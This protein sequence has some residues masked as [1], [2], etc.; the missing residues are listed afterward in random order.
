MLFSPSLSNDCKCSQILSSAII[1]LY[2]FVSFSATR[3][4]SFNLGRMSKPSTKLRCIKDI[5]D[6]TSTSDGLNLIY[7]KKKIEDKGKKQSIVLLDYQLNW[8]LKLSMDS[9]LLFHLHEGLHTWIEAHFC[10]IFW[11]LLQWA[12]QNC[13]RI[14][15]IDLPSTGNNQLVNVFL[16]R[17]KKKNRYSSTIISGK[18][19]K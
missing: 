6:A 9:V 11:G 18:R 13:S 3:N 4:F 17:K 14:S 16:T 7:E 2:D 12:D 8:F 1:W 15:S 10:N 5:T 19:W